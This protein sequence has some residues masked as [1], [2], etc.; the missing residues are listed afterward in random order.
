MSNPKVHSEPERQEVI[1]WN[2]MVY[3]L[4]AF[5]KLIADNRLRLY[6]HLEE[7]LPVYVVRLPPT[8][9]PHYHKLKNH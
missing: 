6:M 7:Y 8:Y 4:P 9:P 2:F 3:K 5:Q 1:I